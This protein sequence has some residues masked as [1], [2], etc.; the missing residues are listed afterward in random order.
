M[1]WAWHS[2]ESIPEDV[3]PICMPEHLRDRLNDMH[4]ALHSIEHALAQDWTLWY[5]NNRHDGRGD[6]RRRSE[7]YRFVGGLQPTPR[8]SGQTPAHFDFQWPKHTWPGI[9][10]SILTLLGLNVEWRQRRSAEYNCKTFIKA[11]GC[12]GPIELGQELHILPPTQCGRGS[13]MPSMLVKA[14]D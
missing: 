3:L 10:A 6:A 11:G 13:I 4:S 9:N 7:L 1:T 2:T 5:E 14:R 12:P 8:Q